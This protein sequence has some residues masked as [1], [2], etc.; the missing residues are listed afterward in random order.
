M[1][2]GLVIENVTATLKIPWIG[3]YNAQNYC[4]ALAVGVA[5]GYPL[6]T[7]CDALY[8]LPPVP[9]RLEPVG[10]RELGVFVD[11]A[12]TPDALE[13]ALVALRDVTSG[14]LW[15]VFG[16]GGDRDKGKRPQMGEIAGRLADNVVVT[17]DNPRTEDPKAIIVDILASGVKP[18]LVEADRRLAIQSAIKQAS[19]GDVILVAG[20][21]HE[22]Y[23][24][25]GKEKAHFSDVEE[26]RKVLC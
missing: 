20:K 2:V 3:F 15:V 17:S 23:Q 22:D 26:V 14:K 19:P 11:Y 24:I 7:V 18:K 25:I 6:E 5:L 8:G 1:R 12:H 16:C 10:N 9:G 21:G 4:A 13:R